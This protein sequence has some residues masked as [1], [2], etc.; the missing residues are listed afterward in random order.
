MADGYITAK[1]SLTIGN[2]KIEGLTSTPDMGS[3]P[4]KIDI[5]SFD[6]EKYKSYIPGLMDP[7]SLTFEFIDKTSNFN[8]AY[9]AE[10]TTNSYE[11]TFPDGSKYAWSGTHRTY[12][13][14][15]AVGDRVNFA[16]ACTPSTELSYTPGNET[17]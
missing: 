17:A 5:T 3:E 15:A 8:A 6:N 16:V 10:G 1:T 4:E 7:G 13:L 14:A 2:T 11:L 9:A 12:K